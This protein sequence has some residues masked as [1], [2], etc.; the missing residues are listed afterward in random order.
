MAL[1]F[2]DRVRQLIN[3]TGT[4]SLQLS[5]MQATYVAFKDAGLGNNLFPYVIVNTSQFEVGVGQFV[6]PVD[7]STPYGVL[8][9]IIVLSNSNLDTSYINFDGT[10]ATA[11]ITNPAELS[12]LVATTP[13]ANTKKIVKWIDSEYELVDQVYNAPALGVG[14]N[15]SIAFYNST[16]TNIEA[17]PNLKFFPGSLPEL[18]VNGVVQATAK[19]FKIKHPCK[20]NK[21]LIHGSLEGPE[22]GIYQR[23]SVLTHYK[24]EVIFPDYFKAIINKCNY[25]VYITSDSFMPIKVKK[26][27]NKVK[28][29]LLLPTILPVEVD[30]LIIAQRT[31]VPFVLES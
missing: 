3:A 7:S 22:H 23:G 4:G 21:Y 11:T 9:R 12:V 13:V 8:N 5:S 19:A 6:S 14:I 31:D 18:W 16:T 15:S 30:Y 17:D 29:T 25:T 24:K 1:I 27:T 28:F 2:K 10:V 20:Q 26:Y